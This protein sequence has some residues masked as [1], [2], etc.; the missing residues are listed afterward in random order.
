MKLIRWLLLLPV[1]VFPYSPFLLSLHDFGP[2][3]GFWLAGLAGAVLLFLTRKGCDTRQLALAGM[4]TKLIQI[5]AYVLWFTVGIALFLFTGPLLAFM[6][7]AMTIALSGLV[8][9]SAVL[10]CK[11]AGILTGKQAVFHG[12]LQFVF[13]VDII[14]AIYVYIKSRKQKENLL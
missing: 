13:C 6:I 12:V 1:I 3:P 7:D 5:P 2:I 8:G 14:S 10:Q 11:K 4:L 9:L